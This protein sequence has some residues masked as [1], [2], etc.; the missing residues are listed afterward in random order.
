MTMNFDYKAEYW[1]WTNSPALTQDEQIELLSIAADEDEIESRFYS[2]LEFGTAGLRGVMGLGLYRMNIYVIRQA[3]YALATL[4]VREGEDA[5]KRG[6]VICCDCRNNSRE[7]AVAAAEVMAGMG[8]HVRLFEDMRPTPELSFAIRHYGAM[9][10]INITASHNPKEYNGYKV[11]WSD[12]AQLPPDHA[13]KVAE[14]MAQNDILVKPPVKSCEAA[15]ADGTME[16][17]GKETDEAFLSK[18]MA[19]CIEPECIVKA[20]DELKIV[21]TPFH[22]AGRILVPE[23]LKRIGIKHLSCVEEQMIPDG[24]FSTVASPNPENPEGFA[25]AEKLANKE[26]VDLLIGTDPDS[27]RI[28]I[29][30][31][32][33][34]GNF[35]QISGN[36]MGVL[37]IDYIIARRK[38]KGTLPENAAVISTIVTTDMASKVAEANGVAC[39][40][41]FTGFKYIAELMKDFEES[42]RHTTIFGYEESFGCLIGSFVRDKDA[43]TAAALF[44]EM[45]AYYHLQGKSLLDVME[46]LYE[47]YGYY[48]ER[49]INIVMPGV[50]GIEDRKKLMADLRKNPPVNIGGMQVTKLRDYKSGTELDIASGTATELELSGSDVLVFVLE[51][52]CKLAVRP[53]GTEPKIKMYVLAHGS[54]KAECESRAEACNI[55]AKALGERI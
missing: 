41:V 44:T 43:V 33:A 26:G 19:Q 5:M 32:T 1:R 27:D 55:A 14:I 36:Q 52:G 25:L 7:F 30:V 8:V 45:A 35:K 21:Y 40:E 20:A 15:I 38:E 22:G 23:V 16:I 24:N 17:I 28:A 50:D 4:I 37:L 11:Y 53:S 29:M 46:E 49:T 54:N 18:V 48:S 34:E 51:D 10:G 13:A 6:C 31:R 42:G 2:P 9:A 12:G 39:Y 47:K 3:T